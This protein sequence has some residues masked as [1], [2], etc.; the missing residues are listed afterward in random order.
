LTLLSPTPRDRGVPARTTRRLLRAG[1]LVLVTLAA[2]ELALRAAA[3]VVGE[4]T[5]HLRPDPRLLENADVAV[6]GD[7]TPFGFGANT[8][9]PAELARRTGLVVVNRSRPAINSAQT[10]LIMR[11]DLA[12][13][14][15]RIILVMTGVNDAWNLAD[16]DHE[17]LGRFG[18]WRQSVPELRLWR[19]VRIWLT[20]GPGASAFETVEPDSRGWRRREEIARAL[21]P[22]RM[23]E[24]TRRS[25]ARIAELAVAHGAEVIFVGY[26]TP[27]WRGSATR[28]N[29]IL[30]REYPGRWVETRSL[31]V[32][33]GGGGVGRGDGDRA[34]SQGGGAGALILPDAFHPTDAGHVLI[35]ERIAGELVRRGLVTLKGLD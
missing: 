18:G 32:G 16:V 24:I 15:P 10:F 13:Y 9:F 22:G 19:L 14:S 23:G 17:L 34:G 35:A 26:P 5:E 3:L 2:V 31:L 27:G 28:V 25:L 33:E 12:R 8:S 7:S 1:A 20:T 4:R 21:D 6:Y 29:E 30:A 11:D